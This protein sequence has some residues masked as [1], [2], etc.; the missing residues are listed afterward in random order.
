MDA[1]AALK[2]KRAGELA[3]RALV[4]LQALGLLVDSWREEVRLLA[5][6]QKKGAKGEIDALNRAIALIELERIAAGAEQKRQAGAASAAERAAGASSIGGAL[7][8]SS[9]SAGR[10][11][12]DLERESRESGKGLVGE[13][14]PAGNIHNPSTVMCACGYKR[15]NATLSV[16]GEPASLPVTVGKATIATLGIPLMV[17]GAV[18]VGTSTLEMSMA[19]ERSQATLTALGEVGWHPDPASALGLVEQAQRRID[20]I[21]NKP[22]E[23]SA[24]PVRLGD[25]EDQLR[26]AFGTFDPPPAATVTLSEPIDATR[27]QVGTLVVDQA[28]QDAH[29][30]IRAMEQTFPFPMFVQATGPTSYR[31]PRPPKAAEHAVRTWADLSMPA[32]EAGIHGPEHMSPSQLSTLDTCAAQARLSRYEELPGVPMWANVGGTAF[33]RCVEYIERAVF[34]GEL[35]VDDFKAMGLAGTLWEKHF[36]DVI[37]ETLNESGMP[38]AD[39]YASAKGKENEAWWA[40]EGQDML[41]RYLDY[42]YELAFRFGDQRKVFVIDGEPVIEREF[43]LDVDG[44]PVKVIPDIVWELADGSIEIWDLKTKQDWMGPIVDTIQLGTQGWALAGSITPEPPITATYFDARKGA[45]TPVFDPI[46]RHPWEELV[47][48]Y[49]DGDDRRRYRPAIPTRSNLCKACPVF[50]ACPVG[51]SQ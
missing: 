50:W 15:P 32:N 7:V 41:R 20:E 44:L 26:K 4:G 37:A 40:V 43:E 12:A 23:P 8:A 6:A 10:T 21:V 13:R 39:W 34:A 9:V 46:E 24:A 1:I 49:H 14:C 33:H 35:K 11:T 38:S 3:D 28:E 51:A 22:S 17:G 31:R 16:E 30:E 42:R 29:R 36:R 2:V 27:T 18:G 45:C 5:G 19:L 48:R 25:L 47:M